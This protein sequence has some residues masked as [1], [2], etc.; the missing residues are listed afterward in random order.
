MW[1]LQ[2]WMLK[3]MW[4]SGDCS[5]LWQVHQVAL[6]SLLFSDCWGTTGNSS[7]SQISHHI[8][9]PNK[10]RV[11]ALRSSTLKSALSSEQSRHF[12][13]D[14]QYSREMFLTCSLLNC[15]SVHKSAAVKM[16]QILLTTPSLSREHFCACQWDIHHKWGREGAPQ[17]LHHSAM[18]CRDF[19]GFIF[20]LHCIQ[21]L[22]EWLNIQKHLLLSTAL[23]LSCLFSC[24]FLL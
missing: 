5:C 3:P 13:S 6:K 10:I 22:K 8:L 18:C 15:I 7:H 1:I 17:A 4:R 19:M 16:Q 11:A 20:L 23:D 24:L 2:Q 12:S 9:M 21:G 14:L